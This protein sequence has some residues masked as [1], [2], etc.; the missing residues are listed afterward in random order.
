MSISM[1]VDGDLSVSL[2][3]VPLRLLRHCSSVRKKQLGNTFLLM[4]LS[5]LTESLTVGAVLPF[6][7]ALVSPEKLLENYYFGELAS[8]FSLASAFDVQSFITVV[9]CVLAIFAAIARLTLIKMT[10]DSARDIGSDFHIKVFRQT[11]NKPFLDHLSQNS[12]VVQAGL[13]KVDRLA[14]NFILPLLSIFTSLI[15]IFA[16][17]TLLAFV[18][19]V[20]TF[21]V[22]IGFGLIYGLISYRSKALL[23]TKGEI[24][25][26]DSTLL[27]QLVQESLGSIRD[28]KLSDTENFHIEKFSKVTRN[29]QSALAVSQLIANLPKHLVE[30][31]GI[32]LLALL[33]FL[34]ISSGNSLLNLLPILGTF[35]LGAHRI[36]PMLNNVYSSFSVLLAELPNVRDILDIVEQDVCKNSG[37]LHKNREE[38]SFNNSIYLRDICFKY[39]NANKNLLTKLNLKIKRG[40]IIGLMGQSGS[41]KSTILNILL[42]LLRPDDGDV[43]IDGKRLGKDVPFDWWFSVI[44]HV[45]Q[46]VFL[47]DD[48]ISRNITLSK[49]GEVINYQKLKL[50]SKV[51]LVENFIKN[52]DHK[53]DTLVGEN[54]A[55]LSGGQRQRIGIAR[56]LYT[57]ANLLVLDEATNALDSRSERRLMR[58]LKSSYPNITMLIVSHEKEKLERLCD[59]TY[60]L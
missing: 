17:M 55:R 32:V 45:P 42:G 21:I 7:G 31:A 30:G 49:P 41:G 43:L 27:F 59:F 48:T 14:A 26:R 12:S 9:F 39:P 52:W 4:C 10:A 47:I 60:K 6:I 57:G 23:T 35:A 40:Q 24:I 58:N 53:L 50:V 25:A 38:A 11:L 3:N 2:L 56:A 15:S 29:V 51:C 22:V 54:G 44:T 34:F 16:V 37:R 33:S 36:L 20:A 46:S 13:K 19:P 18:Q 8:F 1:N 5:G 28:I